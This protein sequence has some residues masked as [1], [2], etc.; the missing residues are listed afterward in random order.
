M[1][2]IEKLKQSE[3]EDTKPGKEDRELKETT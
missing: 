3:N 1:F 2:D